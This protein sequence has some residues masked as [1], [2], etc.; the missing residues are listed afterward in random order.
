MLSPH[1]FDVLVSAHQADLLREAST[2]RMAR[3]VIRRQ[4]VRSRMAEAL[5]ALAMWLDPGA[6]RDR[7]AHVT[8]G[9]T[10]T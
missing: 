2:E 3:Q 1:A 9:V 6:E 4:R 10:L 8:L 7:D 5:C